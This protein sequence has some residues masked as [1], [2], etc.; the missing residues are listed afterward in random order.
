MCC[1]ICQIL[2]AIRDGFTSTGPSFIISHGFKWY[3]LVGTGCGNNNAN[4]LLVDFNLNLSFPD[5]S[6]YDFA[7][8]L[9][10]D[11][12]FVLFFRLLEFHDM[13]LRDNRQG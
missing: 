12:C 13:T 11:V 7:C 8:S 3:S 5:L 9:L 4:I 1:L 10:N 2:H 6:H